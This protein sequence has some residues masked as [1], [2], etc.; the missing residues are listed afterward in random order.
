LILVTGTVTV[1][2]IP[3]GARLFPRQG[4]TGIDQRNQPGAVNMRIYLRRGNV[5]MA[6]QRLQDAQI[7]PAFEQMRGERMAQD[8][9]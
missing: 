4:V 9:G 5:G 1:S 3:R 2:S 8:V 7:G 6:Q